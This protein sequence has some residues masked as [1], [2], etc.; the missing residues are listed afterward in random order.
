MSIFA[1]LRH[2][3]HLGIIRNALLRDQTALLGRLAEAVDGGIGGVEAGLRVGPM[4]M[5][6]AAQPGGLHMGIVL[7]IPDDMMVLVDVPLPLKDRGGNDILSPDGAPWTA[8]GWTVVSEDGAI[9]GVTPNDGLEP[10]FPAAGAG[11]WVRG[12]ALG[13]TVGHVTVPLPDGSELTMKLLINV[14]GSAPQEG[15][16]VFGAPVADPN[17][18]A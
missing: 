9:A 16:I 3:V 18:A 13:Q 2:L 8:P 1:D 4:I 17:P 11:F 15:A 6:P 10:G 14:T 12:R 5:D 7:V